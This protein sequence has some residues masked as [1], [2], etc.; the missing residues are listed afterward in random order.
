MSGTSDWLP[1]LSNDALCTILEELKSAADLAR[2]KAEK[3]ISRN[4]VDPFTALFQIQLLSIPAQ[5]WPAVEKRRQIEKSLQNHIGD[6]HQKLLGAFPGWSDKR[7]GSVVDLVSEQHH[8][9]AEIK[10]KH[11]TL[12]ASDQA[13]LYDKLSGLVRKKGQQHYGFTAYYVEIIPKRPER[14]NIPFTPPD[15]TTGTRKPEDQ[16]IRKID[17]ASFYAMVTG[18]DNALKLI[19]QAIPKALSHMGLPPINS[20]DNKL[21]NGYFVDAFGDN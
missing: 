17:G 8:V 2:A 6:F 20:D 16:L 18:H 7:V 4:V 5:E 15:N 21:M 9:I 13:G 19:Y 1:F 12:K 11:N 14:Y 10:N 3:S